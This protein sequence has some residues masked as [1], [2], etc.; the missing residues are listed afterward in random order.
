[1]TCRARGGALGY[2]A[3]CFWLLVPILTIN[4]LFT[5]RLPPAWHMG[6]FWKDIPWY[7]GVPE[8]VL[9]SVVLLLAVMMPLRF[10]GVRVRRGLAVYVA[11]V[12][13]YL[14]S[15]AALIFSPA[16]TWSTSA[17]GFAAPA[18]TP[19]LWLAGVGLIGDGLFVSWIPFRSWMYWVLSALFVCFHSAHALMVHAR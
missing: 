18:W 4:V 19:G 12:L 9:R 3:S 16:S 17:L 2:L 11:G 8:N 5:D 14:A 10:S 7:V 1:M 13:A 15:W 6:V